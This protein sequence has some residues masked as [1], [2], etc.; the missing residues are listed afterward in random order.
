MTN[1]ESARPDASDSD[2]AKRKSA[3]RQANEAL[4][5][6]SLQQFDFPDNAMDSVRFLDLVQGVE[7]TLLNC[8]PDIVYTHFAHDLNK[9]HRLTHDVALTVFRPQPHGPKP[10]IYGFQVLSSTGWQGASTSAFAPNHFVDI[11]GFEAAKAR[12]LEPYS[13]EMRDAPHAR[14]L[15]ALKA[16][17]TFFGHLVGVTSAEAFVLERSIW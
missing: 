8:A 14:S 11:S 2:L 6:T 4:G 13:P 10:T 9:D 17:D 12:A 7:A 3:A 5:S 16:C 1:G 15:D